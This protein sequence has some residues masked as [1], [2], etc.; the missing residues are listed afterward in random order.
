MSLLQRSGQDEL[1]LIRNDLMTVYREISPGDPDLFPLRYARSMAA[2]PGEPGRA[3]TPGGS[4][5]PTVLIIPDGPASASVLPYDLLRR[6][7]AAKGVDTIMVEHRGV[8][9]SRQ[10]GRGR[11]LPPRA[12]SVASVVDDLVVVLDH[13]LVDRVAVYG[14]GYGAYLAML[15]AALHPGRVRDLVLDSP[16]LGGCDELLSQQAVRARYWDGTT[17]GTA[18]TAATVRRLDASG[19]IDAR[20]AG[21]VVL[22]VHEYGGSQDVEDLVDLLA[23]GRGQLTWTSVRQV[24]TR[25]WLSRTPYVREPDVVSVLEHQGLGRGT[26]ADGGP[27]DPLWVSGDPSADLPPFEGEEFDLRALAPTITAPTLVLAG[28][29]DLVSV[30]AVAQET[31]DLIPGARL[32]TVPRTGHSILDTHAQLA[33]IAVRW[34]AVGAQRELAGHGPELGQ[35]PRTPATQVLSQGLH[36]ALAAERVSPWRLRLQTARGRRRGCR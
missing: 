34:A 31:T 2:E 18:A 36:L 32:L 4:A 24:L 27:L 22:A 13:A 8:G 35:L 5:A 23:R 21:P 17:G 29:R 10:D 25:D 16:M 6:Q 9:L 1:L 33:Q 3:G 20:Q 30:P 14:S 11:D 19:V 12:M 15:L 26:H 28:D 7:L